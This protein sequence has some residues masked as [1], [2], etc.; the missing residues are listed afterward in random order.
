MKR[1]GK[2]NLRRQAKAWVNGGRMWEPSEENIFQV[3]RIADAKVL[4]QEWAWCVWE[5]A[6]KPVWL[7]HS[8]QGYEGRRWGQSRNGGQ[9]VHSPVDNWEDF[10]LCSKWD[11]RVSTWPNLGFTGPPYTAIGVYLAVAETTTCSQTP[12]PFHA[13]KLH[14]PDSFAV[15]CGRM[16]KFWPMGCEQNLIV[17]TSKP[18][19]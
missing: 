5:R 10:S 18:D 6:W 14:F 7:E 2:A 15:R 11:G 17:A 3:A 1:S 19:P 4:R 16:T 13:A 12:V 8:G 9:I